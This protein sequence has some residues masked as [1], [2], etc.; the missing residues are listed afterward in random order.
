MDVP[1]MGVASVGVT[2]FMTVVQMRSHGGSHQSL[3]RV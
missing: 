3:A 1:S 2:V